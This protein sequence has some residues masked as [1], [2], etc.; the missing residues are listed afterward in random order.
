MDP[1][2][3]DQL[4]KQLPRDSVVELSHMAARIRLPAR[5]VLDTAR[6]TVAL[7]HE[8]WQADKNNL[9]LAIDAVKTIETHMKTCRWHTRGGCLV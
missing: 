8:R 2:A 4:V 3:C 5:I 9:L 1:S 7:F 6:E